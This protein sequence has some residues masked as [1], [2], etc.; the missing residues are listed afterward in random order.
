MVGGIATP[1]FAPKLALN[2]VQPNRKNLDEHRLNSEV[3]NYLCGERKLA[4]TTLEKFHIGAK[5]RFILFPYLCDGKLIQLKKL[6]LDRP[7]GKKQIYVEKNCE[8][9]LFGW[10]AV[11]PNARTITLCEG[12][13]DAMTLYQYGINALSLPFGGG[14]N[15]KHAW[16]QYEFDRLSLFDEI[17]LCFDNDGTGQLTAADLINRLGNHRCKI[18]SLPFKDANDCLQ[19]NVTKEAMQTCFKTAKSCDPIEL[20]SASYFVNEVIDGFYPAD[21]LAIGIKMP[22]QKTLDKILFRP[23]ELSVW[24]GTNGHGKSQ[25]LG[26]V[27][28]SAMAQNAKVCIASLELKPKRLLM[29]LTRQAGAVAEPTENY[30]RAIHNWYQDKLWVF[31]LVGTAKTERLLE[32]FLYARQR[33]GVDTFVIDSFMKCGIAEE[34]YKAQKS[35]IEQ[36]CDFKN[37]HNCHIHIVI[38]PRKGIDE[39]HTPGKLDVKGT[40]SITDLAD[41]CFSVWRNKFK[42]QQ[43]QICL[44]ANEPIPEDLTA[45]NDCLLI[46]DKQRNGEWEGKIGLWFDPKS[47]QYLNHA[48]QKPQCFVDYL[49]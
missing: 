14:A 37:Q 28:L 46:C 40:G 35:F 1:F 25:L 29:R 41:N 7:N 42:E 33:Y 19:K 26:H 27:I 12:E 15:S 8:P 10:Q 43:I 45:K 30:I 17:Y 5:D 44:V 39:S 13:I 24:T 18:V 9:G 47:F 34:D 48:S 32:V 22:W 16:L 20:K 49:N 11:D 38:H 23:D 3:K 6:H 4:T 31:D 36:L 21:D 2:F